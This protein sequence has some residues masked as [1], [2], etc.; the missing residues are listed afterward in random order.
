MGVLLIVSTAAVQSLDNPLMKQAPQIVS[1]LQ[2]QANQ[3]LRGHAEYAAGQPAGSDACAGEPGSAE[4]ADPYHS[5]R[6]RRGGGHA[7]RQACPCA[8]EPPSANR[9][10]LKANDAHWR[11][12]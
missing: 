4:S 10:G 11:D 8:G 1:S 6:Q 7:R 5:L 9:V 2:E 12:D 3:Q